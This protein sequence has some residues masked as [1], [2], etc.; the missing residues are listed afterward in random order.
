MDRHATVAVFIV[1]QHKTL[2]HWHAKHSMWLPLGG[3]VDPNESACEAA[4]R[5]AKEEAGVTVELYHPR[6]ALA[7][8]DEHIKPLVSPV[9]VQNEIIGPDHEHIDYIFY[10]KTLNFETQ[11]EYAD[12]KL[13]WYGQEELSS[14]PLADDVRAYALEALTLLA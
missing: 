13:G 7:K 10:G 8:A 11:P 1:H 14:L 5:E 12:M 4:I 6:L 2:L 9:H 3:H